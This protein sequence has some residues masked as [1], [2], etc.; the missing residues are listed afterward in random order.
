M[1]FEGKILLITHNDTKS[2]LGGRALLHR[3]NRRMLKELFGERCITFE[4]EKKPIRGLGSIALAFK[5][6]FD[7]VNKDNIT[8]VLDLIASRNIGTVFVDGSNLGEVVRSIRGQFPTVQIFTFFH[9]VESRFFLGLFRHSR[10]LRSLVVMLVNYLAERKSVKYTDE[11]ICLSDRDSRLLEKIYGRGASHVF[12]I[13]LEDKYKGAHEGASISDDKRFV[14]FVGGAFYA[15]MSGIVWF[16]N[17]VSPH[18]RYRTCIVGKGMEALKEQLERTPD[19]EVIGEVEDLEQW[20]VDAHVVVAPIFDG[21]GMKTKVAEG[22][23]FGKKVIG[24]AEAFSGYGEVVNRAGS[25]CDSATEF[26][27]AIENSHEMV[28]GPVDLEM[29]E[30]YL[31]HYSYQAALGRLRQILIF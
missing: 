25:V 15:N 30:I 3:L 29:R 18:I 17:N 5:G 14:L 31:R 22:L 21:S 1:G 11:I 6:Y 10:N 26:I 9:N 23:M 27:E 12:P 20:Y 7:G 19:V 13:A 8:D 16:A 4:L 24:T 28:S 2:S